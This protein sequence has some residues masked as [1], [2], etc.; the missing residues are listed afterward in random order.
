MNYFAAISQRDGRY[1]WRCS[2]C[3]FCFYHNVPVLLP[4]LKKK[5]K[6]NEIRDAKTQVCH[7]PLEGEGRCC[8]IWVYSN[9]LW[10]Q[11]LKNESQ[12]VKILWT[13]WEKSGAWLNFTF[14]YCSSSSIFLDYSDCLLKL[15]R[16]VCGVWN[17]FMIFHLLQV[18]N[19]TDTSSAF[20]WTISHIFCYFY[21]IYINFIYLF[22]FICI[23]WWQCLL[24]Y[25]AGA[26]LQL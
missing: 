15:Y 10:K 23:S 7:C 19:N 11:W 24:L 21:I 12:K 17:S 9:M 14:S 6:G 18:K 2:D 16:L 3:C 13:D 5:K 8:K 20:S 4:D 26:P 1:L 25:S 22:Y